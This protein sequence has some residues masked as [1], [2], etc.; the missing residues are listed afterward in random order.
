M[1]RSD[2]GIIPLRNVRRSGTVAATTRLH[3][4]SVVTATQKLVVNPTMASE[5]TPTTEDTINPVLRRPKSRVPRRGEAADDLGYGEGGGGNTGDAKGA[6]VSVQLEQV[7]L[8]GIE[9]VEGDPEGERRGEHQP[10]N[11]RVAQPVVD[12]RPDHPTHLVRNPFATLR[13]NPKSRIRK[14]ATTR[15]MARTTALKM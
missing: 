5:A 9:G 11:R 12:R 13:G 14:N 7:G 3:T 1:A 8:E 2:D 4:N 10:A 15:V 6:L